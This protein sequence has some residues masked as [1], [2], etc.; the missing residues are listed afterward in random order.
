MEKTIFNWSWAATGEDLFLASSYRGTVPSQGC[1][2]GI[3]GSLKMFLHLKPGKY[4]S[5]APFIKC[6]VFLGEAGLRHTCEGKF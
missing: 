6:R 5:K 4:P 3:L 1:R 2:E